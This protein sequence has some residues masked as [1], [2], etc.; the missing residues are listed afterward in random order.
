MSENECIKTGFVIEVTKH[1]NDKECDVVIHSKVDDWVSLDWLK[2]QP[3][4]CTIGYV[5]SLLEK[6]K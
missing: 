4:G 6:K 2:K 1:K 3:S 5:L